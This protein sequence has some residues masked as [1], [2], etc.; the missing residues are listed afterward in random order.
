LKNTLKLPKELFNFPPFF[1]INDDINSV[2]YYN[3]E[4]LS[5]YKYFD[6]INAIC[7]V[8]DK[9]YYKK[10]KKVSVT[11]ILQKHLDI[12]IDNSTTLP[13]KQTNHTIQTNSTRL[14]KSRSNL[15]ESSSELC[16]SYSLSSSNS[17]T[18][19]NNMSDLKSCLDSDILTKMTRDEKDL[20]HNKNTYIELNVENSINCLFNTDIK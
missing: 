1:N 5:Y 4:I 8:F 2:V 11:D 17:S 7:Y 6:L 20:M 3:F 14:A 12:T 16:R 13:I 9:D 15:D 10:N 19:S 18:S